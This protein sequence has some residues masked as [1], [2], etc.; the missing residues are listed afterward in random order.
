METAKI[1]EG[2][3]LYYL[4]DNPRRKGLVREGTAWRFSSAGYWLSDGETDVE[5]TGVAW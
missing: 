3:V 5:L 4:H 1:Q 2:A